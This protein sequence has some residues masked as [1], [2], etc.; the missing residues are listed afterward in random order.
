MLGLEVPSI[1]ES[2]SNHIEGLQGENDCIDDI[3]E[4]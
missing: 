4:I 3:S 1:C 2:E